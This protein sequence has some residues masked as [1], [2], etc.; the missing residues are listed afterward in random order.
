MSTPYKPPD[1]KML[2]REYDKNCPLYQ[3]LADEILFVLSKGVKNRKMRISDIRP[4][5]KDFESFY[6]KIIR[7]EITDDPFE[8]IEDIAGVRI[9]CLYRSDLERIEDLIRDKFDVIRAETLRNK[10]RSSFGYRSDHY[11]VRIPK[12]FKGERYDAIKSLKCEIQV[13]TI[14]M[15]AWATVSHHLDYKQEVDIPSTLR[16]DFDALSG[17]F[18]IADSLFEQFRSAREKALES[19]VENAKRDQ[20]NLDEELNLDTLKAYLHWKFPDRGRVK[21]DID[22]STLLSDI[23]QSELNSYRELDEVLNGN[24]QWFLE[25]EK[26]HPPAD[27]KTGKFLDVGIVRMILRHALG[28]I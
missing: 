4:R 17:V 14:S 15:H 21:A 19:L 27:S 5:L 9:I 23:K 16:D 13:R 18:Q 3:Q 24:M 12:D 28:R 22:I 2:R 20:F 6:S 1:K 25:H 11:I 7:K 26:Q 10:E 8:R